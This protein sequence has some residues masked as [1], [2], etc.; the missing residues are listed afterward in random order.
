MI[1]FQA[2]EMNKAFGD[3]EI[4]KS[5]NLVL[6]EKERVGLVGVNGSGKTTLLRC[7][8]GELPPDGGI[9]S[10]ANLSSLGYLAQLPDQAENMTAWDAVMGSFSTLL[11]IRKQIRELEHQISLGGDNLDKLMNRYAQLTEKYEL[12][13]GYACENMAR[14]II[15]GLG[16]TDEQVK[17]PINKFSGGQRTRLN[18][19]RL[20]ALAP[21][22]LLLDEPTNHLDMAS[23]EWLE[24]YIST[25]SGAVLVVSH[26]R[27]FLNKVATRIV[28]LNNGELYSYSGNYSDYIAKKA[29]QEESW[30]RAY[31]KQQEYI[32]NTEDYI[33]R[34]KAGIKSKQARGRQSQLDRLDRI[35]KPEEELDIG[36][37]DIPVKSESAQ[38]VLVVK[39][40]SK[41]FGSLSLLNRANLSIRKGEKVALIGSNG[42]GKST[43]LKII[44]GKIKADEGEIRTGSRVITAYFSQEH[45]DMDEGNTVLDE[46]VYKFDISVEKARSLLGRMLFRGDDVYKI[47]AGLSG[48]EKGRLSLLKLFL[49]GANFLILDEPTNH[50]DIKSREMVE[51]MLADFPGTVLVVSHDRYFI[52]RVASRVVAIEDQQLEYYWG[53][54]SYYH[55]KVEQKRNETTREENAADLKNKSEQQQFRLAQKAQ[56]RQQKKLDRQL[57]DIETK[58]SKME[59]RK[60]E[61]E[62]ILAIPET[63]NDDQLARQYTEEYEQLKVELDDF[64]TEWAIV[65]Q[66]IEEHGV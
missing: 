4:L 8:T 15:Y 35:D 66:Q 17:Q 18:L 58:I 64:Y 39:N 57:Q 43:L 47:V 40:V 3:K 6:Q 32:K 54:F 41:S 20:L 28:E 27:M 38:D 33:R 31:D 46:I 12:D 36:S 14:R 59:T 29:L 45:E 48:G 10:M 21:D 55:E 16:F 56:Q 9:V 51:E 26:D 53:N 11:E 44:T 19:G 2:R 22:I 25:Y 30:Q 5:V 65:G 62:G 50:L 52:D 63:Y 49:T 42:S 13:N 34:F 37:W 7:L 23:V 24:N 60:Q 61:L 1:V